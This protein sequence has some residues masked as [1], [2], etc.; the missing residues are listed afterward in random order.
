MKIVPP[1]RSA[2]EF[3]K[4]RRPQLEEACEHNNYI[5][6]TLLPESRAVSDEVA[7]LLAVKMSDVVNRLKGNEGPDGGRVLKLLGS[8]IATAIV[9]SPATAINAARVTHDLVTDIKKSDQIER[10]IKGV[11]TPILWRYLLTCE[12]DKLMLKRGVW[13]VESRPPSGQYDLRSWPRLKMTG[14]GV[15]SCIHRHTSFAP[16]ANSLTFEVSGLSDYEGVTSS[17]WYQ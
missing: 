12:G 15:D 5:L 11:L 1:D 3:W 14:V 8:W 6:R 7:T 17:K 16:A 13:S 10:R 2:W 4:S 9:P